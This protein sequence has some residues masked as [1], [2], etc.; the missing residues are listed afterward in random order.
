MF[1]KVAWNIC[2]GPKTSGALTNPTKVANNGVNKII[3][4]TSWIV[5]CKGSRVQTP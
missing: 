5:A 4:S 3:I 1:D 2:G